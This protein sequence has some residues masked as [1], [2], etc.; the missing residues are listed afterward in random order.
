M[1]PKM[2]S[3]TMTYQEG[4]R[5][6]LAGISGMGKSY[7]A[8]KT[9]IPQLVKFKPVI[10][11]DR[12]EEYAGRFARDHNPDWRGFD[13]I[14]DFFKHL[15]DEDR[16]LLKDVYVINCQ[17]DEDYINGLQFFKH[18]NKPVSLVLDEAHDLFLDKDFYDAQ[19]YL[20]KLVRYGRSAGIDIVI[21]S[22]RTYDIPPNIRSQFLGAIS[23]KQNHEDDVKA[24]DKKGWA[25]AENVLHLDKKEYEILGEFPDHIES[26]F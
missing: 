8:K 19:K 22:Q 13:G 23:F 25:N 10:I 21:I 1:K 6:L 12:K 15:Q 11:F 16:K 3:Q 17:S 9:L 7:Y 24:L 4:F 5:T 26:I 2:S 14:E 18:L 20:V